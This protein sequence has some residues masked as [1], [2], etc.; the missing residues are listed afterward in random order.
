MRDLRPGFLLL[1]LAVAAPAAGTSRIDLLALDLLMEGDTLVRVT[2]IHGVQ[3]ADGRLGRMV[4]PFDPARQSVVLLEASSGYPGQSR[5]PVPEWAVDTLSGSGDMPLSLVVAYPALREGMEMTFRYEL[6]D[7][8][9]LWERGPW[10]V[11]TPH[12]RGVVPLLTEVTVS[13]GSVRDLAW[14][15]A[16]WEGGIRG[17]RLALEADST[18]GTL[19][20]SPYRDW[21]ELGERLLLEAGRVLGAPRPPDLR[22]AALQATAVGAGAREQLGRM[23]SLLCNSFSPGAGS[24]SGIPFS[25]APIQQLLDVR[26]AGPLEMAV[27]LCAMCTELGI[28]SEILPASASRP[29]LPVPDGWDRFLVRVVDP[30]NPG[31]DWLVEPSA[32]LTPA[33]WVDRT[34]T[35]Y[36]LEDGGLLALPP[37]GSPPGGMT[38]EWELDPAAGRFTLRVGGTGWFDAALRRRFAGLS[39]DE[40]CLILADW[41]WRSGRL[42]AP[43]TVSISDPFDLALPVT[44]LAEGAWCLPGGEDAA[45]R[46]ETA[47][48]L[49]WGEPETLRGGIVR[50]WAVPSGWLPPD[51]P[52]LT[53]SSSGTGLL[54][55]LTAGTPGPFPL[56]RGAGG[57]E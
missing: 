20:I 11:I 38:E 22:E 55:V 46:V 29:A 57:T 9:G 24:L 10:A 45:L 35:L 33:L 53:L 28:P 8:G 7:W 23:R 21:S 36:V 52:G 15:G 17:G 39:G 54:L 3:G 37:G 14:S 49:D 31:E 6:R 4:I 50:S 44:L 5:G 43:D 48:L 19:W 1:A 34:D 13:G 30:R 25:V 40:M 26:S 51:L 56:A 2:S 18:A 27:L 42:V 16:G 41:A 32:H 47:P 12:V